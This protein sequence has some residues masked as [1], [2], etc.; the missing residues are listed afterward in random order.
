MVCMALCGQCMTVCSIDSRF[1][2]AIGFWTVA[3]P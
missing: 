3:R 1:P 2:L